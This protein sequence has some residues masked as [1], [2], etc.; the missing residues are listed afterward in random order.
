MA[1]LF[2][3]VKPGSSS[4]C[5]SRQAAQNPK[6]QCRAR[7]GSV[8]PAAGAWLLCLALTPAF[9]AP[10]PEMLLASHPTQEHSTATRTQ[11]DRKQ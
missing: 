4:H 9:Q 7:A 2:L 5:S 11:G 3:L 1:V 6:C 10:V 8:C